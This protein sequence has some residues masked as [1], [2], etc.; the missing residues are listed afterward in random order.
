MH[1]KTQII[2]ST[3]LLIMISV[4][5]TTKIYSYW[6]DRKVANKYYDTLAT[7]ITELT[8]DDNIRV[9]FEELKRENK[10]IFAWIKIDGTNIDYPVVKG[11][12]ND[13][14]LTHLSNKKYSK[15]GSIFLDYRNNSK[16]SDYHSIIYGH[17][18]KNDTMFSELEKYKDESFYNEHPEYY[19]ITEN[20]TYK[21]KIFSAYVAS[22]KESAWKLEFGSNEEFLNWAQ[23]V[24]KKSLYETNFTPDSNDLI[25]T[26]ST[27]SYE[28]KNARF[29]VS[30]ILEEINR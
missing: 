18:L 9:N 19:I 27:C 24:K 15:V 13:Y 17:T 10:D 4:F 28:F 8:L 3:I 2:I 6:H 11:K 22:T 21:V 29:V 7:N 25:I 5:C 20:K 12:D 26:L 23:V 14:Y 1:K 16:L 30:G